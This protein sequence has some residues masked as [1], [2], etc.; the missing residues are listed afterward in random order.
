MNDGSTRLQFL[1]KLIG[2]LGVLVFC[3]LAQGQFLA[4]SA[5]GYFWLMAAGVLAFFIIEPVPVIKASGFNPREPH[6]TFGL[7]QWL[8]IIALVIGL[9]EAAN[10]A[11]L[12]HQQLLVQQQPNHVPWAHYSLG[13]LLLLGGELLLL[14]IGRIPHLD[15]PAFILVGI[16]AIALFIRVYQI[17]Q[18]PFGIW[19]DEA[20]SGLH[21]RRM[22]ADVNY[23][24]IFISNITFPHLAAYALGLLAF[25]STNI[26]GMRIIT[27]LLASIGVIFAYLVG[28]ELRSP[29]FGLLMAV[30]LATMRWSINFSRIAMT[31]AET[32]TF[33]L[34]TFYA[35]IRLVRNGSFRNALW[36]GI[37][38]ATGFYFYRPYV[39][40][41]LAIG[42]YLLVAYPFWQRRWKHTLLLGATALVSAIVFLIPLGIFA[43]DQGNFY[44]NRLNQVSVFNER[45]PDHISVTDALLQNTVK[46]FQMFHLVGDKN[47]RHNL[48][49]TPML[50]PITGS[51]MMIGLFVALRESRREH[52][53]FA[54]SLIVG[55]LGGIF[56][57]TFE[58]P[59]SL[60]AIG[61][62]LGVI[63]F[64]SLGLAGMT[65]FLISMLAALPIPPRAAVVGG[66]TG[67]VA[68]IGAVA[69]LNL[70]I[71]F[72]RQRTNLAVWREYSTVDTLTARFYTNYDNQTLFYVSP[73]IGNAPSIQF[74]APEAVT[75]SN[76]L[77]MPDPFPLRISPTAPVVLI[78]LPIDNLYLDYLHQ[79]YPNARFHSVRPVD[80]GVNAD[81]QEVLFTVIELTPEDI[82]AVQG[83]SDGTGMLYVPAYDSYTFTHSADTVLE[84]DGEV[85]QVGVPIQLAEGNHL[86]R[87]SPANAPIG[88][89]ASEI[90]SQAP[91]PEQYMFHFPVTANGVIA[92]FFDN[93]NWEGIP[94]TRQ[95]VPSIY[96]QIHIIPMQRPYSVRY[97]GY[98]YAP[99]TGN[100]QF[101]L[102]AID[103]GTLDIDGKAILQT[104][105]PNQL[106]TS[107]V[108][109]E[110]GWHLI[111]VEHQDL[112]SSTRIF[113]SWMPPGASEFR[114]ISRDYFCPSPNLCSTPTISQ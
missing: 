57:I 60:R 53:V 11:N 35:A 21:A 68:V 78:L 17:D 85:V 5:T 79:L 102:L 81:P 84:V 95:V 2:F 46:H 107:A 28:R 13:L 50:D 88:W 93:G 51:L 16:F 72:N 3:W 99:L 89:Q 96:Q 103:T 112:T 65:R 31:G 58:A 100:Y 8:G 92:N 4:L 87:V 82:G 23:R 80:Y 69:A 74:L 15:R 104:A 34:M 97:E 7:R 38:L 113:L 66:L 37:A 90:A 24:P 59:Q 76:M 52:L 18:Y 111:E 54:L 77:V 30:L 49:R 94:V 101:G 19:Y 63:Y 56:T 32:L 41:L 83:L 114:A 9:L 1:F 20:D 61:V 10:S 75:R 109:L 71:Y 29:W 47:G 64:A 67:A 55:L 98:L 44:F 36:F 27:A 22:L 73:L 40:Q 62:I 14:G 86:M 48:P 70:D 108:V 6:F 43:I 33:T 106:T 110:Q 25:G 12:F 39:A 42:I 91:I 26:V 105:A 45:L